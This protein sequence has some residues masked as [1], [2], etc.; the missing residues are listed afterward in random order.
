MWEPR[1]LTTL[2]AFM[3]CYR[4]NLGVDILLNAVFS[5]AVSTCSSLNIRGPVSYPYKTTGKMV[6]FL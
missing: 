1:R 6:L 4:D 2:K 3:A 5:K